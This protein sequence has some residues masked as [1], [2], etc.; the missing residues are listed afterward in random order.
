M[1]TTPC[2]QMKPD[3]VTTFVGQIKIGARDEDKWSLYRDSSGRALF[4]Q[5]LP[6]E[7]LCSY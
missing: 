5:L 2:G 3:M 4:F 1:V 6:I 7:S